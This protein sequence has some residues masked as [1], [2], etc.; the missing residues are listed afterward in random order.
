M[1]SDETLVRTV[2]NV[3][4]GVNISSFLPGAIPALHAVW[5]LIAYEGGHDPSSYDGTV[6]NI[7]DIGAPPHPVLDSY[8]DWIHRVPMLFVA[9]GTF[10]GPGDI[11]WIQSRAM[12]KLP[13]DFGILGVFGA[14]TI[15][16]DESA[17]RTFDVGVDCRMAFR[18]G[19]TQ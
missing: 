7:S 6:W 1:P 2:Q 19:Y 4:C 3:V 13:P 11:T 12:R 16:L 10:Q 9:D 18:S 5:G 15:G 14:T 8:M 17:P